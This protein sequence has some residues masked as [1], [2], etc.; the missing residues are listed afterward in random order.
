M[1]EDNA[2]KYIPVIE[3]LARKDSAQD[4]RI[5]NLIES[6]QDLRRLVN[7]QV[8]SQAKT[9]GEVL[10]QLSAIRETLAWFR[11]TLENSAARQ[12][13]QQKAPQP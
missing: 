11:A 10:S 1:A 5:A 8:V 4:S 13:Y 9:N 6:Q 3:E 7:D 12:Q 2:R